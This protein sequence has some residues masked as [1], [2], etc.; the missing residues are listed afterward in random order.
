MT[1]RLYELVGSDPRRPFS[2]HCWKVTWALA[3]KGLDFETVPVPFTGV[4]GI[5]GGA[6][7][8]VPVIRDG[9]KLVIDSYDIALYLD[10][11]YPDRPSLFGGEGGKALSRFVERWTQITIHGFLGGAVLHDIHECLAP[12]DQAYFRESREKR[13]GGRLE[14]IQAGRDGRR[15]AFRKSLEPLRRMLDGQPFLGGQGPLFAD[16]IVAGAFQWARIVSA[17]EPLAGDDPIA[18]W[19][20]RILDLHDG[21]GRRVAAA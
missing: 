13:V 16:Y 11:T 1:I 6:T 3:H 5:E 18:E 4:A 20:G 14:D 8:T 9:E 15:E 19:F 10:E 2:P 12:A 17:Y 7:K 21:L